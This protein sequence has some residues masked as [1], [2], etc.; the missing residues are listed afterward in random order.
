MLALHYG[1]AVLN[2]G[3]ALSSWQ[4]AVQMWLVASAALVFFLSA[5]YFTQKTPWTYRVGAA[6]AIFAVWSIAFTQGQF[7]IAPIYGIAV[8]FAATGVLF[9]LS[10]R[11][12]ETLADGALG[13]AFG[14]WAGIRWRT[15]SPS[16]FPSSRR[17]FS[18]L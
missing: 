8:V 3:E 9:W 5:Q 4:M 1:A 2:T 7:P 10:S 12:Q 16:N 17:Q 14:L 11:K 6:S 18:P 15:N 13:L